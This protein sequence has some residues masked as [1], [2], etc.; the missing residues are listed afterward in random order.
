M[1]IVK[2]GGS[3]DP[4]DTLIKD[5]VMFLVGLLWVAMVGVATYL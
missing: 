2:R 5:P 4:T 3:G 1:L